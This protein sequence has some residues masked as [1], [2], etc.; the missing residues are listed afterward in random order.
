MYFNDNSY[1][2]L[3]C[4]NGYT[5]P[6]KKQIKKH[7][8]LSIHIKDQNGRT[9]FLIACINN[10]LSVI[11]IIMSAKDFKNEFMYDTDDFKQTGLHLACQNECHEVVDHLLKLNFVKINE[12]DDNG[13]SPFDIA[14]E[15]QF[16]SVANL[17]LKN[18]HLIL[19]KAIKLSPIYINNGRYDRFRIFKF[20]DQINEN[21]KKQ[22]EK[23]YVLI[24]LLVLLASE[25]YYNIKKNKYNH[26]SGRFFNIMKN[27][28]L[29]LM[30]VIINRLRGST[31]DLIS[32]KTLND[33]INF[34]QY[35]IINLIY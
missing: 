21:I 27:L 20:E 3:C 15:N 9:P 11:K 8:Y 4:E 6:L 12:R 2:F 30:M 31:E 10:K 23:E 25:D 33:E 19:P 5:Q 1:I 35:N 17:M 22:K 24:Y 34:N 13:K 18:Q 28:P 7:G 14:F 16:F 32:T 29:E 26:K